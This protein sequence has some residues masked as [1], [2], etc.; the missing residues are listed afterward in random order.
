MFAPPLPLQ[1]LPKREGSRRRLLRGLA[2]NVAGACVPGV[3]AYGFALASFGCP[4]TVRE[5]VGARRAEVVD[6]GNLRG[7][8]YS[9]VHSHAD[10]LG[11]SDG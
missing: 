6:G 9:S 10:K 11:S 1:E 5:V 7:A 4:F 3:S 2:E 8:G